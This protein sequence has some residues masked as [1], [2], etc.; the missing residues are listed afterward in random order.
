MKKALRNT[1]LEWVHEPRIPE[2]C[3][4]VFRNFTNVV[5]GHRRI[6]LEEQICF[7]PVYP[8]G[9]P[10]TLPAAPH[11]CRLLYVGNL[12]NPAGLFV[13]PLDGAGNETLVDMLPTEFAD[14]TTEVVRFLV[15]LMDQREKLS[16]AIHDARNVLRIDMDSEVGLNRKASGDC[17]RDQAHDG[18]AQFR[19]ADPWRR[20]RLPLQSGGQPGC[21]PLRCE[22]R[23]HHQFRPQGP[24]RRFLFEVRVDICGGPVVGLAIDLHGDQRV[25]ATPAEARDAV[26]AKVVRGSVGLTCSRMS[27]GREAPGLTSCH[28]TQPQCTISRAHLCLYFWVT[29]PG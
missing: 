26:M 2:R 28:S 3:S 25:E 18:C 4:G 23:D 29:F 14:R 15:P 19:G 21:L 8:Y 10:V 6:F 27:S 12:I 13:I 5:P 20:H 1:S 24:A 17:P 7:F 9:V 16:F 22:V 11:G